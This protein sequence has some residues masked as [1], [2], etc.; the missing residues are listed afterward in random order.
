MQ[1][2]KYLIIALSLLILYKHSYATTID[3]K[4]FSFNISSD[5]NIEDDREKRVTLYSK[6]GTLD[7][8]VGI[9][10]FKKEKS[11]NSKNIQSECMEDFKKLI[12]GG[13]DKSLIPKI[14][15]SEDSDKYIYT[16]KTTTDRKTNISITYYCSTEIGVYIAVLSQ[17]SEGITTQISS[18]I[19]NTMKFK[20]Q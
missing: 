15:K 16:T 5:L 20:N 4:F 8:F 17:K 10:Y 18:Q 7:P 3:T 9:E 2:S 12:E 1:L 11:G 6:D 13:I 14:E 19:V